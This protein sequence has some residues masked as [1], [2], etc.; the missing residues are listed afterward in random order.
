MA[1]RRRASFSFEPK[2]EMDA[3]KLKV[4]EW[5]ALMWK[6]KKPL[7]KPKKDEK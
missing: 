2:S 1:Q 6:F 5:E 7:L 3:S 4:Q